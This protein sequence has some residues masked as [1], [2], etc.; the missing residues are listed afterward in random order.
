MIN[1]HTAI[2]YT[3]TAPMS[4]DSAGDFLEALEEFG[5][6]M[7]L[8]RD[9]LSATITLTVNAHTAPEAI[10][11]AVTIVRE[12]IERAATIVREAMQPIP[13]DINDVRAASEDVIDAELTE[14]VFPKVVGFAEIAKLAGVTRQRAH[15]FPH[16][17]GLPP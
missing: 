5:A 4:D 14:P 2:G 13:I 8:A 16:I 17:T 9:Y 11:R 3:T 7:S 1:W 10:E 6:V 12:A 15:Q